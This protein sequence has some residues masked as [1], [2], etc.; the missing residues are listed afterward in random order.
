MHS[1]VYVIDII[2]LITAEHYEQLPGLTFLPV[3]MALT[4]QQ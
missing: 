3:I 1:A 4:F 2:I